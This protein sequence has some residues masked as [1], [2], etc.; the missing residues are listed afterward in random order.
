MYT[1]Y[2]AL[3]G[4]YDDLNEI[5]SNV[6][7]SN[8]R[9]VCFTDNKDLTSETWEIV[10]D[11]S[12]IPPD[13][14]NRWYKFHP[15][16]LFKES[17]A[18]LYL[19]SNIKIFT[20]PYEIFEYFETIEQDML[21]PLHPERNCIYQESEVCYVHGKIDRES[22]DYLINRFI[23]EGYPRNNGLFEMS[24]IFSKHTESF[25]KCMEQWWYFFCNI[26]RR[27]QLS[28]CFCAWLTETKLQG[29]DFHMQSVNKYFFRLPHKHESRLI[30]NKVI[31][32]EILLRVA[33]K[34][35]VIR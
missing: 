19:D 9:Y 3:F 1:V 13:L 23:S 17:K 29:L 32:K 34:L 21:M 26:A 8:I 20:D 5:S 24:I 4:D 2:T 22:K 31:L 10:H 28:F 7:N 12:D 11:F 14:L 27:D 33:I 15:H 25:K 16:L 18:T 30:K 6:I 35:R